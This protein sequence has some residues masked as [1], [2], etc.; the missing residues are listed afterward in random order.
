MPCII[1]V[2]IR[3]QS[4]GL[5]KH[6][7]CHKYTMSLLKTLPAYIYIYVYIWIAAYYSIL[8][9]CSPCFASMHHQAYQTVLYFELLNEVAPLQLPNAQLHDMRWCPCW[10]FPHIS[11]WRFPQKDL[12]LWHWTCHMNQSNSWTNSNIDRMNKMAGFIWH[13][14]FQ[15]ETVCYRNGLLNR[16]WVHPFCSGNAHGNPFYHY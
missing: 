1:W 8:Q 15:N 2:I 7:L 16:T 6:P 14:S 5:P 13:G 4:E 10:C 12:G 11:A 3:V 9:H